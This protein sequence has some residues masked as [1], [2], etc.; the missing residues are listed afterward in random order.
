MEHKGWADLCRGIKGAKPS[1]GGSAGIPNLC[2]PFAPGPLHAHYIL[3][4]RAA[5][6]YERPVRLASPSLEM[7]SRQ[8]FTF[9]A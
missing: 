4:D 3:S 1:T 2:S 6:A 9:K 7:S 8:P 5:E